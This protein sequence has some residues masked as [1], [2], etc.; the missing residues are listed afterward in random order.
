MGTKVGYYVEARDSDDN[1]AAN[2]PDAPF[3]THHFRVE[4]YPS[5]LVDDFF[6]VGSTNLLQM[7]ALSRQSWFIS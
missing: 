2:P 7:K 3:M 5:L 4:W 6:D 1:V